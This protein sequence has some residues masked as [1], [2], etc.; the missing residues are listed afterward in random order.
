MA[1]SIKDPE[2]DRLARELAKATG[3]SLTEAVTGALREQLRIVRGDN[4]TGEQRLASVMRII[5]DFRNH[6]VA[7]HRSADEIIGYDERGLP[8]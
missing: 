3:Q 5:E 4:R 1:L 8:S 6:R 2:A 7:D